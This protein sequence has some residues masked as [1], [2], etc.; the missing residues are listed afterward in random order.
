M[1]PEMMILLQILQMNDKQNIKERWSNKA[2]RVSAQ[3][4]TSPSLSTSYLGELV[5]FHEIILPRAPS[6]YI[7]SSYDYQYPKSRLNFLLPKST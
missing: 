5:Y 1:Y 4:Y 7:Y 3:T 2:K 6:T